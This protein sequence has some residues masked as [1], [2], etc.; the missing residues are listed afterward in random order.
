MRGLIESG[1]GILPLLQTGSG[2]GPFRVVH[3]NDHRRSQG[4]AL[5]HAGAAVFA[6]GFIAGAVLTSRLQ[7]AFAGKGREPAAGT[8][9]R[10]VPWAACR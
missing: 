2:F 5:A 8:G 6:A 4:T 9:E 7:N 3:G 1:S 10:C